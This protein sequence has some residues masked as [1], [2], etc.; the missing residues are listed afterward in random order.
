MARPADPEKRRELARRAAVV[1]E[2]EGLEIPVARLAHA[3]G[4]KRPTLL[5]HFATYAE[6][7]EV[8]LEDLL[9]EQAGY[10]LAEI[11]K[12][13]HPLEQLYAHL[14]AVHA[15]H[16]GKEQRVVFL[17]Q[18][19]AATAG[20]RLPEILARA[21]RVFEPYRRAMADR[22]RAGIASGTVAPCDADALVAMVRALMDG[23]MIQRVATGIELAPLHEMVWETLLSPLVRKKGASHEQGGRSAS[24]TSR[25]EA[26]HR[27][28]PYLSRGQRLFADP[29]D[30]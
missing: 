7:L 13:T 10:V 12:H 25:K 21:G 17:S 15:F 11:A 29:D 16:L 19:I 28:R 18:G 8:A 9:T 4:V 14:R 22:I 24:R 5:Y 1:L 2:R 30:A 3:L 27:V 26:P 20:P 23:L 6:I